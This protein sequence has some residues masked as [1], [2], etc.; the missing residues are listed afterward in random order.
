MIKTLTTICFVL[1]LSFQL[2]AQDTK[3]CDNPLVITEVINNIANQYNNPVNGLVIFEHFGPDVGY[4]YEARNLCPNLGRAGQALPPG[5]E[6]FNGAYFTCDGTFIC[7]Y[8]VDR[9]VACDP[10]FSNVNIDLTLATTRTV[11]YE[12]QC[13][14]EGTI[15]E[16]C[17]AEEVKIEIPKSVPLPPSVPGTP[18]FP[19]CDYSDIRITPDADTEKSEDGFII[20]ASRSTVYNLRINETINAC[21]PVEYRYTVK[22]DPACGPNT[23]EKPDLFATYEWLEKLV[24]YTDCKNSSVDAYDKDGNIFLYVRIED[25]YK[26]YDDAGNLYCSD[27]PSLSCLR[28]YDL[29]NLIDSWNCEVSE[30]ENIF[31]TICPGDPLP[32]IKAPKAIGELTFSACG[33]A[34][35]LG[36]PPVVCPCRAIF[37]VDITPKEGVISDLIDGQ[38]YE[39]A[40]KTTTTYTITSRSGGR[41]GSPCIPESFST[42]FTIVVKNEAECQDIPNCD[43]DDVLEPVCGSDGRT[44]SN[45]CFAECEGIRILSE[46]ECEVDNVFPDFFNDYP[47]LYDLIDPNN[48]S[49]YSVY[50]YELATVDFVY[51][52]KDGLGKL[53][54]NGDLYCSDRESFSCIQ[55]YRLAA[56]IH[57]W[58]CGDTGDCICTAEY[59]PVCGADGKTYGN[60]CEAECAGVNIIGEGECENTIVCTEATGTIFFDICDDGTRYIFIGNDD[61]SIVDPYNESGEAFSGIQGQR[62]RY[63]YTEAEFESPCTIASQAIYIDCIENIG[64]EVEANCNKHTGTIFF[65]TCRDGTTYFLIESDGL[66]YDPYYINGISFDHFDGQA[67]RFDFFD[68]D[69]VSPCVNAEKAIFITCIEEDNIPNDFL[70]IDLIEFL[71]DKIDTEDCDNTRMRIFENEPVNLVYIQQN[72]FGTLYDETGELYCSDGGAISCLSSYGL[73]IPILDLDCSDLDIE[74]GITTGFEGF[75]SYPWLNNV[76][77]SLQCESAVIDIFDNEAFAYIYVQD[78]NSSILYF[79]DGS[80]FC[81]SSPNY[82]C[83]EAYGL[84][85]PSSRWTCLGSENIENEGDDGNS[86]E[87]ENEGESDNQGENDSNSST[88]NQDIKTCPGVAVRLDVPII[89]LSVDGSNIETECP[90]PPA[91]GEALPCPCSLVEN[92][93]VSPEI[94]IIDKGDGFILVNPEG[95]TSY[96]ITVATGKSNPDA[97][98]IPEKYETVYT[99]IPDPSICGGLVNDSPEMRIKFDKNIQALEIFPNPALDRI[100]ISGLS[101]I[102]GELRINNII[103]KNIK[104][105]SNINS[106]AKSIDISDLESGIYILTWEHSNTKT[107]RKFVVK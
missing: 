38:Y 33:P 79:E 40:P 58:N 72:G 12:V 48:C 53:Y 43:C 68:A 29:T 16:S 75:D 37:S 59:N 21:G 89:G 93:E 63:N 90:P 54:Q 8:G 88:L 56:P 98:C 71:K 25:S 28:N 52:F 39:V 20:Q 105:F 61:G 102:S 3:K 80:V 42:T 15:I 45:R 62:V 11:K 64:E 10:E 55:F 2:V 9:P 103:G 50:V 6:V 87:S 49:G 17:R 7:S 83:L 84:S 74:E 70:T 95:Q 100:N 104:T 97:L 4:F 47:F 60:L 51:V 22:V 82:S 77:S 34:G 92:F 65:D 67:I 27:S 18:K 5:F 32:N 31:A 91:E 107:S 73:E 99:I 13:T 30:E 35:P 24:D 94:G 26:L 19:E 41:A 46:G 85:R 14:Y 78:E 81:T 106:L 76:S 57:T 1:T 44:Y 101:G 86:S 36:S 96:T 23:S 69:F 66:I